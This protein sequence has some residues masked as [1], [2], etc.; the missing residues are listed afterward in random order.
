MNAAI[1]QLKASLSEYLAHVKHGE[2]L[3]ITERGKPVAVIS[4]LKREASHTTAH[5]MELERAGLIKTASSPLTSEFWH[6][7]RPKDLSDKA[8]KYLMDERSEDR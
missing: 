3:I 8:Q 2:E 1:Y 7:T 4:P 5:L 6:L